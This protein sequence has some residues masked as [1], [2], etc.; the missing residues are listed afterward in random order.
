MT[1]QFVYLIQTIEG[2]DAPRV[3]L[4]FLDEAEAAQFVEVLNELADEAPE[5]P[6]LDL[7]M[8]DPAWAK[9]MAAE[10]KFRAEHPL[11]DAGAGYIDQHYEVGK[12]RLASKTEPRVEA[13]TPNGT[14]QMK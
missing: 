5:V 7:E 2:Y 1:D 9:Y 11:G 10:Q 6:D 12:L 8:D 3:V 4:A 14:G 13:Q